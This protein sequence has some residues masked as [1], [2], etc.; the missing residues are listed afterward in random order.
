MPNICRYS[1]MGSM[2]AKTW[3]Y[4]YISVQG[5]FLHSGNKYSQFAAIYIFERFQIFYSPNIRG[6]SNFNHNYDQYYF[7][8]LHQIGFIWWSYS[9]IW[10]DLHR[11]WQSYLWAVSYILREI[12]LLWIASNGFVS[13]QIWHT[14]FW[15]VFQ[16]PS[17]NLD[18][19]G[20]YE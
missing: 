12:W 16:N 3:T 6:I 19:H 14:C 15:L 5:C 4:S 10:T 13:N 11:V 18:E 7:N 2:Y 9:Q 8:Y 20:S 17:V 1:Y